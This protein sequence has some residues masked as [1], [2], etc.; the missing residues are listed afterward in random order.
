MWAELPIQRYGDPPGPELEC[1][2]PGHVYPRFDDVKVSPWK[3][4]PADVQAWA[5]NIWAIAF[6]VVRTPLAPNDL[7]L[8]IADCSTLVAKPGVWAKNERSTRMHY[9]TLNYVVPSK[10]G[11][12]L[13]KHMILSMAHELSKGDNSGACVKFM[14]EL[15]DVP[16]SLYSAEP[17]LRFSYVWIPFFATETWEK[18]ADTAGFR[19]PGF[20]PDAWVGFEL[21]ACGENHILFDPHDSV[22]W[23]D[24]FDSLLTFDKRPGANVRLFWPLGNVRAYVENM[25]F[26]A[27]SEK[28]LIP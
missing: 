23:Y 15:H 27:S 7:F 3:D 28:V 13:A 5:L 25:H 4:V 12:N 17:F 8:W 19:R 10:R 26:S 18:A 20:T 22:A 6:S 16:R 24:S 11:Q 1:I 21:Y 2:H 9:V 14:F